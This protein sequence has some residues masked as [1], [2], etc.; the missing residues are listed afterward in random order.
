[1]ER[2]EIVSRI[3]DLESELSSIKST[4]DT[5]KLFGNGVFGKLGSK[6]SI[7]YAIQEFIQVTL[8][9]QLALLMLI[10]MLESC[11]IRVVSANTDGIVIKC[12][13]DAEWLR[14]ECLQWWRDITQ[15]ET[16]HTNYRVLMSANIN[17]YMA[18][19]TDGE[20]KLKGYFARPIPVGTS[21][22]NPTGEICIDALEQYFLN[23]TPFET[24]IRACTDVRKFVHVRSVKGGGQWNGSYLGK[25][26]RWY[27]STGDTAEILY[28]SN[29]NKVPS[30]E[31]CRPLMQLPETFPVDVDYARY[32]NDTRAM[33]ADL[34]VMQP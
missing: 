27:Y 2:H 22:P 18:I 9:G 24:T 23:G 26:V 17:N 34:G 30:S 5:Y 8:T 28:V 16:E 14:D 11:G 12:R 21:W 3:R 20:V 1:M 4:S 31:G 25:A 13:R 33:C 10:E 32:L 29:G 15:F 19:K 6:W 7:F